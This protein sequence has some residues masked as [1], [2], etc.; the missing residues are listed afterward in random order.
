MREQR[1]SISIGGGVGGNVVT[2]DHNTV[3]GVP[4][5]P[6]APAPTGPKGTMRPRL[7][8][9]VD[10]VGFGRR[11]AAGKADLQERLDR[12]VTGVVDGLGVDPADTEKADAGDS[13]VL[14]LPV[15]ADSARVVPSV[16]A[17]MADGLARDNHRYRDRMR[18]RMSMASG[19]VGDG[20]TGFTGELVIDLH[21]LLDS[22]ALRGAM[23]DHTETDL[24]LLVSQAL[25]D[26][27]IR[28]GHLSP[29]G[30]TRVEVTTKE[31]TAPAWLRLC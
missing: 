22:T 24:A 13:R 2:G 23:A 5:A 14:F 25:Y 19:L 20:P 9:V 6:P 11:D 16:V 26:D 10:I 21:R 30:F 27:V 29:A 18:L 31:F 3:G 15:G 12:L 4:A 7:G 8:F 1:N 17:G 28:P